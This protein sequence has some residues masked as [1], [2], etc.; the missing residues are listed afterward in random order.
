MDGCSLLARSLLLAAIISTSASAQ[1]SGIRWRAE[2]EAAKTEAR[3]SGRLV[4]VHFWTPTCAP[5]RRLDHAVF[6]QPNVGVAIESQFVPVKLNANDH[7]AVAQTYGI[8]AVPADVI[9]TPEGQPLGKLVSPPTPTAYISE[10]TQIANRTKRPSSGTLSDQKKSSPARTNSGPTRTPINAAYAHL[11]VEQPHRPSPP[12]ASQPQTYT[13]PVPSVP[14]VAT[15]AHPQPVG[16]NQ[17]QIATSPSNPGP[18]KLPPKQATLTGPPPS[19]RATSPF[20]PAANSRPAIP[21]GPLQQAITNGSQP[22]AEKSSPSPG[23]DSSGLS[24]GASPP[25][26]DVPTEWPNVPPGNPPLAFDGYCPV[27]MKQTW[28]WVSGDVNWGAIHRGRTYLF[29]GKAEQQQFLANPDR[30][31]PV[32]SGAD[33][34]I[35]ID[36]KQ[37]IEGRREH[38]LEYNGQFYLFSTEASLQQFSSNPERYAEGV[39][40]AMGETAEKTVR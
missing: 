12:P 24:A 39:R 31:S 20:A 17:R 11:P 37:R 32:L 34:V 21:H 36:Q 23:P 27:S 40:Q 6:N 5:C 13:A 28:K 14:G 9:I 7:A 19:A 30:F 10:L 35:A 8:R 26:N 2:I 22:T 29:V 25:R 33:A 1:A 38:G 3:Q 16:K 4:L 18:A 15:N